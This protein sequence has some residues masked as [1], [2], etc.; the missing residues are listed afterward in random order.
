VKRGACAAALLVSLACLAG[1]SAITPF[2]AAAPGPALPAPWAV[3]GVPRVPAPQLALVAGDNG[4]VLRSHAHG[5][6]GV[7]IHPLNADSEGAALA[8]RWKVDRVVAA[9]DM[10]TRAGDDFAARVYVFFDVPPETL[11]LTERL[12]MRVARLLYGEALPTAAICYVWD[13]RHAPGAAR[14]SPYTQRVRIVVLESGTQHAG[15]W[16]DE[17]RDLAADFRAAFGGEWH[18]PLPAIS[19]VAAG[20]DTDQTGEEVTAW[21]SDLR[22]E[23]VR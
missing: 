7:A 5:A 1:S 17:R 14:W 10:D 20:N 18:G 16:V 19:G 4:V 13:N 23:R 3:Q 8:W 22:L 9:G 15:Q 6:A 11:P 2:S 21:F 12:K